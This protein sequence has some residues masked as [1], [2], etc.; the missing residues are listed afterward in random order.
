MADPRLYFARLEKAETEANSSHLSGNTPFPANA[1][2]SE[3]TA[4]E[5]ESD[6]VYMND[7]DLETSSVED[8]THVKTEAGTTLASATES[9]ILAA[10]SSF[11]QPEVQ[12][13]NRLLSWLLSAEEMKR[14]H[15]NDKYKKERVTNEQTASGTGNAGAFAHFASIGDESHAACP[16]RYRS[17]L[18]NIK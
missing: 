1:M 8:V 5:E 9:K 11:K 16:G 2:K 10:A 7:V 17:A 13:M 3:S 14:Q 15:E 4:A 12:H 18:S 6:D